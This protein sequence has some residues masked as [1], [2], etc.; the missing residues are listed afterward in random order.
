MV[1]FGP[2]SVKEPENEERP[3]HNKQSSQLTP[4][5]KVQL[6]DRIARH[7]SATRTRH[8]RSRHSENFNPS[9]KKGDTMS[10]RSRKRRSTEKMGATVVN[11]FLFYRIVQ[12]HVYT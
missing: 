3:A 2:L 11:I 5:Q 1:N 8:S 4:E 7:D 10:R 6:I 12:Y 9:D